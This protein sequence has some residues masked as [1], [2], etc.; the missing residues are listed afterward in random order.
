MSESNPN[1]TSGA[2]PPKPTALVPCIDNIPE[3]M[4]K[5]RRWVLWDY[6]LRDDPR[7]GYWTKVPLSA[8]DTPAK[9]TSPSTWLPFDP[10]VRL[11][12]VYKN[13]RNAVAGIGFV[14][15]EDR[16][17]G[18]WWSGADFDHI[19]SP[20]HGIVP[21]A[22]EA[23]ATLQGIAYRE[24][25][26]SGTGAKVVLQGQLDP[27][28]KN[29]SVVQQDGGHIEFYEKGRFF[30]IT[31]RTL[32]DGSATLAFV[33]ASA[34]IQ[35]LQGRFCDLRI[36]PAPKVPQRTAPV[37]MDDGQL[38]AK[39]FASKKGQAIRHLWEGDSSA[40]DGDDSRADLALAGSLMWWTNNDLVRSDALFRQSGLMRPKWDSSRGERTYGQMTLDKATATDGGYGANQN[41]PGGVTQ[42]AS[43]SVT[44][45]TAA[46]ATTA[47]T[48]NVTATSSTTRRL[49]LT[50]ISEFEA[51][52]VRW[53]ARGYLPRGKVV[54]LAGDGG[55]GKS[56]ITLD[57]AACVSTGRVPLGLDGE[58]ELP[59]SD[60]LIYALED[61]PR[62]TISPR[63]R[64]AQADLM[65]VRIIEGTRADTGHFLPFDLTQLESLRVT[66]QE[67]PQTRLLIIDPIGGVL[68]AS[69]V[70]VYKDGPVRE[71]LEPLSRLAADYELLVLCIAHT[72]K[73]TD[74]K[75]AHRILG[76]VGIVNVS[77]LAFAVGRDD[78][79]PR[80]GYLCPA[81]C[82]LGSWPAS[83]QFRSRSLTL[84]EQDEALLGYADHLESADRQELAT[85]LFRLEWLG[86]CDKSADD[87]GQRNRGA[88]STGDVERAAEWLQVFL[89]KEPQHSTRCVEEGNKALGTNH[90]LEWWREEVL[91]EKLQGKP[92]QV[93]GQ[94]VW[95]LPQGVETVTPSV[96]EVLL[97]FHPPE[98]QNGEDAV[99]NS[100]CSDPSDPS[101]SDTGGKKKRRRVGTQNT[102]KGQNRQNS[103]KEEGHS[104]PTTPVETEEEGGEDPPADTTETTGMENVEEG[105]V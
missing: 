80:V 71:V 44:V 42:P 20:E 57:V 2:V 86:P 39:M 18:V 40:Y 92:Q 66:L 104:D 28:R 22:A 63:L 15:G 65:R 53:I 49:E 72:G 62:D 87:L 97:P 33:D 70:D 38:L 7:G 29:R 8:S 37:N 47:T 91:K 26:P 14:L 68:S 48:P 55:G 41:S 27:Q 61:D 100:A 79:D 21:W 75:S 30:T 35:T 101:G 31:G 10:A 82:N 78:N 6:Q 56:S 4:R 58:A 93:K 69:G 95:R 51:Q 1:V 83:L 105:D 85:Q 24:Y 88:T 16:E 11:Y 50:P 9:S 36:Q 45:S 13:S 89:A 32:D 43:T 103:Q 77:R 5:A 12:N 99:R 3:A 67:M 59:P 102:Q 64:A 98:P 25:S 17:A 46:T 60:V 96:T 84:T 52:P 74:R 90:G 81:K 94:W 73:A 76:S 19:V 23:L 34:Q 54:M